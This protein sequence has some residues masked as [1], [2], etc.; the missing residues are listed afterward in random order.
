[1]VFRIGLK[2]SSL[3]YS[4][5]FL[6]PVLPVLIFLFIILSLFI[7]FTPV[8]FFMYYFWLI[9]SFFSF[10]FEVIL[11]NLTASYEC[12]YP[13]YFCIYYTYSILLFLIF[14][15]FFFFLIFSILFPLFHFLVIIRKPVFITIT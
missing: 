15:F 9:F 11:F 1:M 5:H 4:C 6:R 7:N 2:I 13:S 14:L 3:S 12:F 10:F 8:L